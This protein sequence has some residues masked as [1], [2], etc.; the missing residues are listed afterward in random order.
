MANPGMSFLYFLTKPMRNL[1]R[2]GFSLVGVAQSTSLYGLFVAKYFEPAMPVIDT[3]AARG[4]PAAAELATGFVQRCGMD[5]D[6]STFLL[7][8]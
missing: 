7:H 2:H 1:T 5:P 4:L 3:D 6:V 8:C